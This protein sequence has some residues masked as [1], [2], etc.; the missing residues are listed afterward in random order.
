MSKDKFKLYKSDREVLEDHLQTSVQADYAK[1]I[2]STH[3]TLEEV[4]FY[5]AHDPRRETPEY[6]TIHDNL[7]NQKDLPCLVCGVRHSTLKDDNLN[8]YG[9]RQMETHHHIVEWALANA[10]DVGKFNKILRPFLQKR[11]PDKP[12]YNNDFNQQQVLDWIDH[13][14]DNLWVLCDIHHRHKYLGIHAITYPI[15]SPVDLLR[16]D[17]EEYAREQ[18]LKMQ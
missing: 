2:H 7:V 12:D 5:P 14:E 4:A 8:P 3:Q 15:W 13:S 10:V 11:H 16:D 9:A 18:L 1:Q 17:F 6:K